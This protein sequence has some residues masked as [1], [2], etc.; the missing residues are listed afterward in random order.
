MMDQAEFDRLFQQRP[1]EEAQPPDIDFMVDEMYKGKMLDPNKWY[2][3]NFETVDDS[4]PLS[5]EDYVTDPRP[6]DKNL[7]GWITTEYKGIS[8]EAKTQ[9]LV[10]ALATSFAQHHSIKQLRKDIYKTCAMGTNMAWRTN[11]KVVPLMDLPSVNAKWR[12]LDDNVL[13]YPCSSLT[14]RGYSSDASYGQR[15]VVVPNPADIKPPLWCLE[16]AA[17]PCWIAVVEV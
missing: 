15:K 6:D 14:Y 13:V 9:K 16:E 11:E 17:G 10:Q 5:V 1:F 12:W 8:T 4:Y 3:S 7:F 2:R